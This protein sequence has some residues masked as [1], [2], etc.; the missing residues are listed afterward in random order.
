LTRDGV[1][2]LTDALVDEVKS[3]IVAGNES[4]DIVTNER[5]RAALNNANEAILRAIGAIDG[6]LPPEIVSADTRSALLALDEIVGKTY[7]EDI[8]GRIFSKFCVGK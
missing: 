3:S 4:N 1:D 5:H 2:G 6:G 8:L 7:T